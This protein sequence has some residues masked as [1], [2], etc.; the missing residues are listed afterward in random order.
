MPLQDPV[1][2]VEHGVFAT[3]FGLSANGSSSVLFHPTS[4]DAR[5]DIVPVDGLGLYVDGLR[6]NARGA[7][8]S[9]DRGWRGAV[10]AHGAWWLGDRVGVGAVG[11]V[12]GGQDWNV[13]GGVRSAEMGR[14]ELTASPSLVFG[15]RGGGAYAW[16][17][18]E[19]SAI[20]RVRGAS[21]GGGLDWP[22]PPVHVRATIGGEFV[23]D[24]LVGQ[25]A[26]GEAYARIGAAL[27]AG[28]TWGL[29]VWVGASW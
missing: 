3:T 19:V 23:S 25:G 6:I 2:L 29:G 26:S 16:A 9:R 21:S 5:V 20:A 11:E 28:S 8:K 14:F 17:G 27:R 7:G 13:D 1:A 10:G 18:P 4:L 24:D 12:S 15:E 22:E